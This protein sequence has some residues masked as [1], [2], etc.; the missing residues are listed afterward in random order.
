MAKKLNFDVITVTGKRKRAL[1]K[2][3]IQQ[4]SGKILLNSRPI[5]FLS[6]FR[7]LYLSEPVRILENQGMPINFNISIR[8]SGGGSE[9]QIEAARLSIARALIKFTKSQ[10]LKKVFLNYDRNMLIQD[11][12]HKESYK[13]NDSKARAKR[14]KS[15]R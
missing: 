14:Q 4:G 5:T 7:K 6:E 9:G 11:T 15:Y 10:D 12:R 2:A 1:A 13:P 3:T 8:V